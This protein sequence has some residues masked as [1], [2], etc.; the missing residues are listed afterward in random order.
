MRA[1]AAVTTETIEEARRR[2]DMLA[3]AS[4]VMRRSMTAGIILGAMPKG[5]EKL[6]IKMNGDGPIC[7]I[8]VD[9][10]A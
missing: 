8:L 7:T 10:N 3:V 9:A 2:N 5:E 4:V 1:F 6:T